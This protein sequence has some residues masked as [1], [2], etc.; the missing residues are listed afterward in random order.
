MK[1]RYWL[2]PLLLGAALGYGFWPAQH[3]AVTSVEAKPA[4]LAKTQADGALGQGFA[5]DQALMERFDY[6]L[7][8]RGE[9]PD[10]ALKAKLADSLKADGWRDGDIQAAL[11]AFGRYQGYLKALAQVAK[12]ASAK[13][14]DLKAA[15]A[16]RD[17]VRA[18]YFSE[19]ERQAL[20]GQD[21]ALEEFTLRR[22]EINEL[23][24]SP[25]ERADWLDDEL[26]KAPPEVQKAFAPSQQL[27]RLDQMAGASRDQ[28]AARFGDEAADRLE[29]AKAREQG[30]KDKVAAYRAE[31]NRLAE[32]PPEQ[33]DQALAQYRAGHFTALEGR[34]LDAW[35][36]SGLK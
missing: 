20:W 31:A 21:K 7:S 8:A 12:P 30:W 2:P 5:L 33:R 32:L 29:A 22:L 23:G 4:S 35:L 27:D 10:E 9:L 18:R 24:L 34:R 25:A 3:Q 6:W 1:F 14:A 17:A 26:A 16:E 15:W 28:L 36:R 19:A 11:A 13:A